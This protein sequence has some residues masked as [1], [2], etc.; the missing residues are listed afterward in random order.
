MRYKLCFPQTIDGKLRVAIFPSECGFVNNN[1]WH[2]HL[3]QE[4]DTALDALAFSE[5]IINAKRYEEPCPC[6][7]N[8]KTKQ[9]V[10]IFEED[11]YEEIHLD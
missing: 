1:W 4:F 8:C 5:A 3:K 6:G 2:S 7:E 9:K 10:S 11:E